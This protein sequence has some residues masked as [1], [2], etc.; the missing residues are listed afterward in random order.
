MRAPITI[1]IPVGPNG[2]RV[3]VFLALSLFFVFPSR[4]AAGE[5]EVVRR[6]FREVDT[7]FANPG[8]GW[9]SQQ[10]SP[11]G[12]PRFPCS[13]VYIRFNWADV[14]PEEGQFKWSLDAVVDFM[15]SNHVTLINDN[16]GAFPTEAR[17]QLDKLARLAGGR[18]VLRELARE[19]V[20]QRGTRLGLEMTWAKVGV[21]KVYHPYVLRFF[22]VAADQPALSSDATADL[23]DWLP[24][25]HRLTATLDLPV[26]LKAGDYTLAV[27]ITNPAD[28][29][30]PFRLAID[31]PEKAGRYEIS[32]VR[33][34]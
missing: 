13:V 3:A 10:R 16:F 31:V 28:P 7:P 29:N 30:R 27:A 14:E 17:P 1:S 26:T 20:V 19:R 9:M 8:Q 18:F 34:E 23:R 5:R 32:T 12:E 2:H 21:G 4:S 15:L 33:L 22:L 25:E 6:Q 24:G 11:R